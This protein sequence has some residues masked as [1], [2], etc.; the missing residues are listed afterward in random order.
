MTSAAT[1]FAQETRV[2]AD[3]GLFFSSQVPTVYATFD[4]GG[5]MAGAG[6]EIRTGYSVT[7][8]LALYT[9]FLVA[10]LPRMTKSSAVGRL[11]G[12][13]TL[14]GLDLGGQI[15]LT[16]SSTPLGLHAELAL[17]QRTLTF[18]SS[19]GSTDLSGVGL[20]GTDAA[21]V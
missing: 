9:G 6:V 11:S 3:G 7:P 18:E 13:P 12:T 20:P 10:G 17:A 21:G 2:V 15:M 19:D 4:A 16:G 14:S 5:S 1:S 8:R